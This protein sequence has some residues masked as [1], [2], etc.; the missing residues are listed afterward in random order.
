MKALPFLDGINHQLPFFS[1]FDLV[2]WCDFYDKMAVI[3][4][5]EGQVLS[6]RFALRRPQIQFHFTYFS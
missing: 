3:L 4:P 5:P 1:N 2:L 6:V